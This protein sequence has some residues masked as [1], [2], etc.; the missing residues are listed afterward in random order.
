LRIAIIGGGWIGCHLASKLKQKHNV[1]IFEKNQKLFLETSYKN[2]NRLHLGY[3]YSRNHKTRE[4]CKLTHERF[5]QDYG[6][7][8]E[9]VSNNYYCVARE[10]ILDYSTYLKIFD[11]AER[12]ENLDYLSNIEGAI[13]T[14]EKYINFQSLHDHFNEQ[15]S[16]IF[17]RRKIDDFRELDHDLIIN[18]T[19]NHLQFV[20]DCSY[21][22]TLTLL[23]K[24]TNQTPFGALTL[25]EGD[26]FS[27]Y[28]YRDNLVTVTDVEHTPIA[29]FRTIEELNDYNFSDEILNDRI[30]KIENKITKYYSP[31]KSNFVYDGYFLST[32]VKPISSSANRY[33]VVYKENNTISCY[34]GKIQGIYIIEEY[35]KR[36][37]EKN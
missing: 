5:L 34:T 12:I 37:I 4:L 13:N 33:P 14:K 28:P 30:E 29:K 1:S 35:V 19:N 22:L 31:F 11:N 8:T 23:Y 9:C 32:K 2:Q 15:L 18:C 6:R 3:H 7:F 36:C 24:K 17:F 25:V 10:S 16:P 26:F 27:I 20:Q 21:E